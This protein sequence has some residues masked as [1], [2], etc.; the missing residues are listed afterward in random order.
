MMTDKPTPKFMKPGDNPELDRL[1]EKARQEGSEPPGEY[2]YDMFG[3]RRRIVTVDQDAA[4][5]VQ[6]D[7]SAPTGPV[8]TETPAGMPAKMTHDRILRYAAMAIG[9]PLLALMIGAIGMNVG[10]QTTQVASAASTGGI[11]PSVSVGVA[12]A[13]ARAVPSPTMTAAPMT[14][15]DAGAPPASPSNTRPV[16]GR[17]EA[18]VAPRTPKV[19]PTNDPYAEVP[20]KQRKPDAGDIW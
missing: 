2:Y 5:L 10:Q 15:E 6:G 17:P 20:P 18:A 12:P 16:P 1:L 8:V 19:Q 9:G 4:T 3:R 7:K 11:A 13:T 14:I